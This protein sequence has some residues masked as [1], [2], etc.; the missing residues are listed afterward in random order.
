[1]GKNKEER[2]RL[3]SEGKV[4]ISR[5]KRPAALLECPTAKH[6]EAQLEK[7]DQAARKR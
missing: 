6:Q 1:L 4:E 5:R 7:S 2:E 3:I